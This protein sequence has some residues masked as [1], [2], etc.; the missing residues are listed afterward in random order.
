[1]P[2]AAGSNLA[3]YEIRSKIGEGGMGEVYLARDTKLERT[4]ALKVL[5]PEV[6]HDN[7]QMGRFV[8]E[9][10]AASALSHPNVAHIYEIDEAEGV[11]FIAMEYVEG[12]SLDQII[13]GQP[14]A[15]SEIVNVATQIA[16]A[17]DEAHS[18]KIVHRDIKPSNVVITPRG[19]V[20]VLDFGLA[21]VEDAW[22]PSSEIATQVKTNPGVIMGTVP[23][24]S[25]E[26]AKGKEVDSRTDI[27]SL[28]VVMY[29]MAT[30]RL[31][32]RSPSANEIIDQINRAQ[33]K[34]ISQYNDEAPPEL[35]RIIRKCLEKERSRRYQ[36]AGDLLV[37]LR[38]LK[39]DDESST[40]RQLRRR[41][42]RRAINS[43]AV[44]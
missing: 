7:R 36:T 38:N 39:R 14:L 37:D 19:R 25:P 33:P 44:L 28:G 20:K 16:D 41:P 10:K 32:F 23:Y 26:Q 18:K 21:K 1:M 30:G 17:L 29:Q 12:K 4:V 24:M 15:T 6:A 43:L 5:S 8:L 9:A 35:E 34:S 3:Q 31:P 42:S 2:L 22:E 11:T 40:S 13:K 27:W